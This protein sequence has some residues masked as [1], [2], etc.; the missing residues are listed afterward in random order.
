MEMDENKG[1]EWKGKELKGMEL[2]EKKEE[3]WQ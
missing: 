2:K 3:L 1:E